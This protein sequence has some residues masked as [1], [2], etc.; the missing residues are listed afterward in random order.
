MKVLKKILKILLSL[1]IGIAIGAGGV[2][3]ILWLIG[4]VGG[5]DESA[6]SGFDIVTLLLSIGAVVISLVVALI[7]HLVLHEAGHL[8]M[9]LLTGYRFLSFRVFHLML[10]KTDEGLCLKRYHVAGTGGQCLLDLPEDQDVETAPWFWYN[11]G[12]VLMNI[13]IT[14]LS[15]IAL[16]IFDFGIAGMSFFLMMAFVGLYL[17]LV[18]GIPMCVN[19]VSN[20]GHNIL[21]LWRHPEQKRF[22]V[23]L[24][25]VTGKQSKGL[26]PQEMPREWFEDNPI[27]DKSPLFEILN[28]ISFMA[29]LEDTERY[30]EARQVAEELASLGNRLPLLYKMEIGGEHVLLELLTASRKNVVS[31][32]W[33]KKLEKYTLVNSKYSPMK[34]A[35]LH[36]YALLHDH[37]TEKADG[38]KQQLES[39]LQDY[40]MP[41]EAR[42]AI[43]MVEAAMAKWNKMEALKREIED[44]ST[45]KGVLNLF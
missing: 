5:S 19:G 22:F 38:Y 40:A 23:R 6:G 8:V 33:T 25:Q 27:D 10:A 11:A 26:R 43:T 2:M 4:D 37:D 12:G 9:G 14:A 30:E 39:H 32:L 16:R 15:I 44:S 45:Q 1:L 7:I 20:D 13:L 42:T 41:G 29:F 21:S 18:N 35:V 24:L 34:C 17:T 28:R 36:A 31:R 3:L